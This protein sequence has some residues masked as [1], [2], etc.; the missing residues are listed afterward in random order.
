MSC[1]LAATWA[2]AI[3]TFLV[4]VV[5]VVIAL[6]Q[7]T[8]RR[9]LYHPM[10]EVIAKSGP[11]D[12][13]QIKQDVYQSGTLIAS[14]PSYYLRVLVRNNGK[15]AARNVEVYAK[16][17]YRKQADGSWKPVS[18]FPPMNLVWANSPPPPYYRD[19]IYLRSLAPKFEK[20]CDIG[21]I[22]DPECRASAGFQHEVN[23]KLDPEEVSLSFDLIQL[24]N[25][26]GYIVSQGV[27]RLSIVV[28][29]ENADPAQQQLEIR[30]LGWDRDERR[31]FGKLLGL[32]V[33][34]SSQG[35]D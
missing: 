29:A 8:W 23:P 3:A 6:Y 1:E 11:P 4:A 24:P 35:L 9:W 16:K 2:T 26:K 12:C 27:Y 30:V 31:M 28:V 5:A 18:E 7:E 33:L 25:H 14:A 32:R 15:E 13:V 34:S 21:H 22:L 20:Y 10:L 17:L 19:R